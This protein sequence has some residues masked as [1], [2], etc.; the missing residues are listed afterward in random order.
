MLPILAKNK[1][2]VGIAGTIIKNRSLGENQEQNQE[3]TQNIKLLCAKL[4]LTAIQ[5]DSP[6]ALA[7]AIEEMFQCM[8]KAPHKEGPHIEP[9]SY[10]AQR[11]K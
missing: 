7:D 5:M 6:D 11:E 1:N 10:E 4:I 8:D 9:H 3:D 2:N